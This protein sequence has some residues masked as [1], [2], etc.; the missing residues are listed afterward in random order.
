M[1][2]KTLAAATGIPL[3][4]AQKWEGPI[5]EALTYADITLARSIASFLAQTGH[6]SLSFTCTKE[7]GND[8]YL[9]K[10]DTGRL[11]DRL[12]NTPEADGDGQLYAGRGLIQVT[13]KT[14]YRACSQALFGDERLVDHPQLLE[15]PRY[16]ALSAA[17]FWKKNKLNSLSNDILAQTEKVNGGLNGI[18]DRKKRMSLALKVLAP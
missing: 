7:M 14:N 12:G 16:A 15:E 1:D 5:N 8:K 13:G 6:E 11:A 10:Y 4:R 3:A 2:A 9:S 17:W 18:E